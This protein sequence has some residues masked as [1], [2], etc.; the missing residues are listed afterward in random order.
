MDTTML[1]TF[2]EELD[3]RLQSECQVVAELYHKLR[4]RAGL[5]PGDIVLEAPYPHNGRLKCD[6]VITVAGGRDFWIEVKG[7]F[8]SETS[9]TRSRKHTSERSS[10]YQSCSKL[11]HLGPEVTKILVIYQNELFD[12]VGANSWQA[13][14]DRC[15][16]DGILLFHHAH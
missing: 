13:V 1:A 10:P 9:S 11:N 14:R 6:M 15:E 5:E 2:V 8:F 12:P 16:Q 3:S 4:S 7:Y